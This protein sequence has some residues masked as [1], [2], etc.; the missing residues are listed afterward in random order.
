MSFVISVNFKEA[1]IITA[2]VRQERW[3]QKRLYEEYYGVLM[4]VCLRYADDQNTAMDMLH[5]SFMKI[6]RS[7]QSYQEGT[8]L[9]AWMRRI[10]INTCID[11]YRKSKR[12]QV[13]Q[14]DN[15]V[16]VSETSADVFSQMRESELLKA[17]QQL[18]PMY[19]AIFNLFVIEGFSHREIGEQLGI[20]ES[21]SRSN[22]AKARLKLQEIIQMT[23]L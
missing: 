15:A 14:L 13:D 1:D 6:F 22:L 18:S 2:C 19:R 21:T 11:H 20:M 8:S 10:V 16:N 23:E 12:H 5:D 3:A 7:I 17:I 4:G 9:I